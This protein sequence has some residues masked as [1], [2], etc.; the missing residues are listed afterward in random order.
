M[1]KETKQFFIAIAALIGTIIGVG[2][3]GVPYALSQIG[4]GLGIVYFLV[5]G[6]IQ[7]LQH[8][9][10][11]EAAITCPDKLRLPG[12][13]ERY[14][15]RHARFIATIS[16]TLGHWGGMLAYI[17]V[18]GQFL[19]VLF[20]PFFGGSLML[21]QFLWSILG[22][23]I[24]FFGLNFVSKI[25]FFATVGLLLTMMAII[26]LG[27]PH[28]QAPHLILFTGKDFILPYGVIFFALSGLPAVLEMEDIL[29]GNHK[30]YRLAVT[31]GTLVA[32]L[33]TAIFGF[34][35]WGV[36][37]P[38]IT[39]DA[40]NGLQEI[41]G[42]GVMRF[43]ALF[44]F[45]AVAT[46]YFGTGIHL[47]DSFQYDAKMSKFF[48]WLLTIGVPFVVFLFGVKNFITIISFS[49]AVFG[50]ITAILVALLYIV[51]TRKKLVSEKPLGAPLW[52][53]YVSIVVISCGALYEIIATLTK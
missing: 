51:I 33:L 20:S 50:G 23:S 7:L 12:L 1:S 26:V 45:L 31:I 42:G 2:V 25:D 44:G 52:L 43:I 21:Y 49:G 28:V 9:F 24:L 14:L 11:A 40:M 39:K 35:V 5:L 36:V 46:S 16:I 29:E 19:F 8:L 47:Q 4:V 22:A 48:S 18:G 3:F 37:G 38:A 6:G 13:T 41:L 17:I 15:G 53:A 30:N 27:L 10:F 32:T 34:V